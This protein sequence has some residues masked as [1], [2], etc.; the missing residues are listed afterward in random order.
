MGERQV[1]SA[2][3]QLAGPSTLAQSP[4]ASATHAQ[5]RRSGERAS[6]S[7]SSERQG[8]CEAKCK[9]GTRVQEYAMEEEERRREQPGGREDLARYPDRGGDALRLRG[10]LKRGGAEA[11]SAKNGMRLR[12]VW[13]RAR[14][15]GRGWPTNRVCR[16]RPIWVATVSRTQPRSLGEGREEIC[17]GSRT[18]RWGGGMRVRLLRL[19][20][21]PDPTR[22]GR[23]LLRRRPGTSRRAALQAVLALAGHPQDRAVWSLTVG[24]ARSRHA[25]SARTHLAAAGATIS[26]AG[27]LSHG[28]RRFAEE[29]TA[30]PRQGGL[31]ARP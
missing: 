31:D 6:S 29:V 20:P 1:R 15:A 22:A 17:C 16:S 24:R 7:G 25:D 27:R 8:G 19:P 28:R 4:P 10:G 2:S 13:A 26:C 21:P 11:R 12:G 9:R 14:A 3:C 23:S 30:R 18:E 5:Y